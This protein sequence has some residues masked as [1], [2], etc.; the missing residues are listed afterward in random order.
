MRP[1]LPW[2]LA[3]ADV[4][5]HAD[6]ALYYPGEETLLVAD[7]HF[8]KGAFFRRQG[9][10]VPS[11]QSADD[12]RRLSILIEQFNARRLIILGDVFHHRPA[13]NE[14]FFDHFDAWRHRHQ[15]IELEAVIGNHDRH[16]RGLELP[17]RWHTTLDLGPFRLSHEPAFIL[18]RHVL[19]GHIHPAF[20]LSAAGDRLRAPVFWLR[21]E[22]SV[23]PSFGALTGGWEVPETPGSR[24]IMVLDGQLL[25][26]PAR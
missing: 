16:V 25:P 21:P 5:L 3:G 10:A 6:K 4:V 18:G 17:I 2:N 8:G 1:T 22:V 7:T 19:A 13:P 11:G 20:V 26:L 24:L 15:D 14:P 23:L 9:L 12:L